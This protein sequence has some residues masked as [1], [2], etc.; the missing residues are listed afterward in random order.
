M[1]RPKVNQ[2]DLLIEALAKGFSGIQDF[3]KFQE[4]EEGRKLWN[5]IVMSTSEFESFQTLFLN[6]YIPATN[7]SIADSWRQ[8]NDSKYKKLMNIS[9]DDLKENLYETIRLGYVGLFHK[10]ESY[11][12]N[13]VEAVNFLLN[14]LFKENNLLSIEKYCRKKY[15]VDIYKSHNLFTITSKINYI[16]NC[17]K[18]YDGYPIKEPVH[19]EFKYLDNSKRIRIDKDVFRTDIKRLKIHCE[20]LLNQVISMGFK[21]YFELDLK[22][23]QESLKPEFIDNSEAETKLKQ[24]MKN[25]DFILSDFEQNHN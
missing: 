10:Y 18:H 14:D 17:I 22:V 25:F 12:K 2:I 21:Q 20:S 3:H 9:K 6:Y 19:P 23:I 11:L 1:K 5:L 15:N 24:M 7:Q 16:S 4:S 8:I 13:L